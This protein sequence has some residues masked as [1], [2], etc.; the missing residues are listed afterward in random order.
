MIIGD[1]L[2]ER[3]RCQR[4]QGKEAQQHPYRQRGR[5]TDPVPAGSDELEESIQWIAED[6]LVEIT[7]EHIRLRKV[8]L[9][10]NQR[11]KKKKKNA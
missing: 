7:P 2:A 1:T 11:P 5:G 8:T 9:P 10:A 6:E 3:P 4:H